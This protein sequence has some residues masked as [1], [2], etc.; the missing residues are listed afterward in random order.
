MDSTM[1][2]FQSTLPVGEATDR[3][4]LCDIWQY[5]FQSTLPVGEATAVGAVLAE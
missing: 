4:S 1:S 5:A 3:S 2:Q